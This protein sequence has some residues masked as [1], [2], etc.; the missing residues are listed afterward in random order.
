[1]ENIAGYIDH[2]LLKPEV[3]KSQVQKLCVE[4]LKYKFASVCVN[5]CYISEAK[6]I[7]EGSEV[8]VCCVVGFPLGAGSKEAKVSETEDALQKG[9]QEVDMVL[10]IGAVKSDDWEYVEKEIE[11]IAKVV[12][13]DNKILKVILEICLLTKDEI[14]KACLVAEKAG[15]DF[16]KTSTGFSYGGAKADDV[17]LM[18]KTV[19][20]NVGVKASGGISTYSQAIAMIE[21]GANRIG[22]SHGVEIAE[23]EQR[24]EEMA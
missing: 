22:T 14:E 10:S 7:L 11:E 3:T 21:A 2:T 19:K 18:R 24:M 16:V 23:E 4:A 9:A 20:A 6:R 5:P 13:K 1:M 17:R 15:A 8:K 12:H